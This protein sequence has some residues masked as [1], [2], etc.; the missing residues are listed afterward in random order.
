VDV[1]EALEE[2]DSTRYGIKLNCYEPYASETEVRLAG[3]A[4]YSCF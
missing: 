3:K 4:D 2:E 1:V